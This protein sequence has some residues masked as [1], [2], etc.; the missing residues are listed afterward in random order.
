MDWAN[1]NLL[2]VDVGYSSIRPSTGVAWM[3]PTQIVT[4]KAFADE[5][6]RVRTV[7]KGFVADE[8][9][10]DGPLVPN[11]HSELRAVESRF[12][13]G[14]FQRRCKPGFSHFGSGLRLRL[15]AHEA[16]TIFSNFARA[17]NAVRQCRVVEAFPNAF[18]GVMLPDAVFDQMPRLKRGKKFDWL[19]ER[20]IENRR[21]EELLECLQLR[22]PDLL[23]LCR[24]EKDHER[25][26]ALVCVLTAACSFAGLATTIG[27]DE[28]GSFWMPPEE[29]WQ[30]WARDA[31]GGG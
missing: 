20:A 7:P 13:K 1:V 5:R 21:F 12:S 28:G 6:S 10:V 15:A 29:L 11:Q 19:Y 22:R 31:V 17:P 27:D 8:I 3:T 26:A 16:A 18:L 4:A 24:G 2:G 25:R 14:A 23:L 30:T 9:A